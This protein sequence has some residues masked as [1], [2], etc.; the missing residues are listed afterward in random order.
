[1]SEWR[2]VSGDQWGATCFQIQGD[3]W[4]WVRLK[5]EGVITAAMPDTPMRLFRALLR[6]HDLRTKAPGTEC[7]MRYGTWP[8]LVN[9]HE[10]PHP[11]C[12]CG[13]SGRA[14]TPDEL[15]R[16]KERTGGET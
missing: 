14:L 10:G 13:G 5:P 2:E 15:T 16:W 1:M 9:C 12:A 11:K 8:T 7:A 6:A 4:S 3:S